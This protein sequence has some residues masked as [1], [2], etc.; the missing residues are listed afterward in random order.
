MHV[1][2]VAGKSLKGKKAENKAP[3]SLSLNGK[4][5]QAAQN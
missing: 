4:L 3:A 1:Y 5:T 2:T